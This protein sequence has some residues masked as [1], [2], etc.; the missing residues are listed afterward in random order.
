MP[1]FVT[2]LSL[3]LCVLLIWGHVQYAPAQEDSADALLKKLADFYQSQPALSVDINVE[4][5]VSFGEEEQSAR[6]Y[7]EL[8]T[9]RPNLLSSKNYEVLEENEQT[10]RMEIVSD[11]ETLKI[12]IPDLDRYIESPAP[13]TF[14][15]LSED[16]TF[17]M[18]AGLGNPSIGFPILLVMSDVYEQLMDGVTNT[19]DLGVVQLDGKDARHLKFTQDAFNWEAWISTA[20]QPLLL[21]MRIDMSDSIQGPGGNADIQFLMTLAFANWSF[22]SPDAEAFAFTAPEGMEKADSLFEGLGM[23][24]PGY[25]MEELPPLLGEAAP[26]IEL[27]LLDGETFRL[28]DLKGKQ[29]AI[30]DFWAT[31][32]GP[33]IAEM[34]IVEEVA[35]EFADRDVALFAINLR[36][37]AETIKEFFE[38]QEL[39]VTTVLDEE[40]TAADTYGVSGIPTLVIVDKQGVVQVVHIG[41]SDSLKETLTQE[42]SDILEGKDLAAATIEEHNRKM[43]ELNASL[44]AEGGLETVWTQDGSF[45]S[46]SSDSSGKLYTVATDG[47]IRI[48][49]PAGES[50]GEFSAPDRVR[51]IR[52]ASFGDES[53]ALLGYAPWG[54]SVIAFDLNG[55]LLWKEESGQGID[56]VW[57]ADLDG[58]GVD[59]VVVGYNGST[60]LHVY[61]HKGTRRWHDDSIGNVWHVTTGDA[62]GD[63]KLNVVSTSAAGNVHL[64]EA[65]GTVVDEWEVPL[66]AN[67]I[68]CGRIA[69]DDPADTIFVV[70]SGE[71]EELMAFQQS[72]EPLWT[73]TFPPQYH[74]ADSAAVCPSRPWVAVGLRGGLVV[75]VD[76]TTGEIIANVRNQGMTPQVSWFAE[77]DAAEPLLVIANGGE[78]S[79]SRVNSVE[80]EEQP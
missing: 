8:R 52:A 42:L 39:S 79:V 26:E 55:K 25:G 18:I 20:E 6:Q 21:Q 33:C 24:S 2:L 62:N 66:Y 74:H 16:Q 19:E 46:A 63:G 30:L 47:M 4:T 32:C 60:G 51:H 15:G 49:N 80:A 58:D 34:P 61:D 53:P 14:N 12:V 59:E 78:L 38:E 29:V 40:G 27:P 35:K 72:A 65:D 31:W 76:A 50:L 56:D 54:E 69:E 67:M 68:R 75:V 41:F 43:E 48:F 10:L 37:D 11:G 45:T 44:P 22:E 7:S 17:S 5:N 71:G 9:K 3:T 73:L 23:D 64:F 28:S 77:S 36:E 13:E 70:G 1:R 57:P